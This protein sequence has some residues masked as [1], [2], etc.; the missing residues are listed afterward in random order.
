MKNVSLD[1][2]MEYLKTLK[3]MYRWPIKDFKSKKVKRKKVHKDFPYV[4][5]V[6][7]DHYFLDD[8]EDWC[9]TMF[10]NYDGECNWD[11][12]KKSW[13]TWYEETGLEKELDDELYRIRKKHGDQTS[14]DKKISSKAMTKHFDMVE[15][16][17]D[18][19]KEHSHNG[20]WMRFYVVKTGY[21]YGYQDFCFKDI[22]AAV[23]FKLIWK[24]ESNGKNIL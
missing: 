17:E 14:K 3:P 21:D 1:Q 19:P 20:T 8:I 18:A 13:E 23:H 5:T 16:R 24:G 12:C 10:G 9:R 22:A 4:I 7:A 15:K 11:G 6:E 2:Y